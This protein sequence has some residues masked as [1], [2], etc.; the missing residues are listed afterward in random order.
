LGLPVPSGEAAFWGYIGIATIIIGSVLIGSDLLLR[1]RASRKQEHFPAGKYNEFTWLTVHFSKRGE[2]PDTPNPS[3]RLISNNR[4]KQFYWISSAI[5][6]PYVRAKRIQW[7]THDSE[8]KMYAYFQKHGF[9]P[10]E[11]DPELEELG[12]KQVQPI[13]KEPKAVLKQI[14]AGHLFRRTLEC[15]ISSTTNWFDLDFHRGHLLSVLE[16]NVTNGRI[17]KG[18]LVQPRGFRIDQ[19]SPTL[20]A[21]VLVTFQFISGPYTLPAPMKPSSVTGSLH[22]G[23][24]GR[25]EVEVLDSFTKKSLGRVSY[26]RGKPP[27]NEQPFELS[28]RGL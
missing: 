5:D 7:H 4:T 24:R 23:D 11:C 21:T 20:R 22:K 17:K 12:L 8:K 3:R 27:N 26:E 2:N 10:N 1:L 19:L 28:L 14:Y 25:L 13:Q 16:T 15:K 6:E 18:V 9:T